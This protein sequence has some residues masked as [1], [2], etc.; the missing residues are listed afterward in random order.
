[1]KHK[2]LRKAFLSCAAGLGVLGMGVLGSCA[3]IAQEPV[4]KDARTQHILGN[5]F[6]CG[7]YY[8]DV[9]TK[10]FDEI[11]TD[12]NR[13]A[14]MGFNYVYA[15]VSVG[16]KP[17]T[18]YPQLN[19]LLEIAA[20][21]NMAVRVQAGGWAYLLRGLTGPR[22]GVWKPDW[23]AKRLADIAV[24]FI[25][26]YKDHPQVIDFLVME[27]PDF[28]S[29]PPLH[30]YYQEI[31]RQLP[32]APLAILYN[33]LEV[34]EADKENRYPQS[35]GS[36]IYPFRNAGNAATNSLRTPGAALQYFTSRMDAFQQLAKYRGQAFE[37]VFA[38]Y[39]QKETLTPEELLKSYYGCKNEAARQAAFDRDMRLAKAG[40]RGFSLNEDGSVTRWFRYWAPPRYVTALSWISLASGA[41][42]MAVYHWRGKTAGKNYEIA[43]MLGWDGTGS[44]GLDEFAAFAKEIRPFGKLFRSA[45]RDV[46]PFVSPQDGDDVVQTKDNASA[47]L[48]TADKNSLSS[49]FSVPGY[50]G[51]VVVVVNMLAGEWSGGKSP[52]ALKESDPFH[53]DDKGELIGFTPIAQSREVDFR[54]LPPSQEAVDLMSGERIPLQTDGKLKISIA[55]G[56]GRLLFV[57]PAGSGEAQ[58]LVQEYQ[59]SLR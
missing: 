46:A 25:R 28:K 32:D 45:T 48:Q 10:T 16:L 43:D 19:R 2:T 20:K 57:A 29:L 44:R 50:K 3:A 40:N 9:N 14:D 55:P 4:M 1:M 8:Y 27:E 42:S 31:R 35:A 51:K 18:E 22:T 47:V 6:R 33:R 53:F 58:R 34:S 13:M 39:A 56:G 24:P 11:E 37:A 23:S 12:I 49:S 21:R 17:D 52:L 36:D 26:K 5:Q 30:E 38:S 15:A 54:V 41:D 59:L 7:A